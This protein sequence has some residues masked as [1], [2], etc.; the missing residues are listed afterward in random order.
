MNNMLAE[1]FTQK[2]YQYYKVEKHFL[3]NDCGLYDARFTFMSFTDD[4]VSF[5]FSCD[6]CGHTWERL[7]TYR[8]LLKLYVDYMRAE[9]KEDLE[10]FHYYELFRLGLDFRQV[11]QFE[12]EREWFANWLDRLRR[13]TTGIRFFWRQLWTS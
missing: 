4:T 10:N 3:C 2:R 13:D 12:H 5:Q 11:F 8:R 1:K 6:G 9:K 7:M